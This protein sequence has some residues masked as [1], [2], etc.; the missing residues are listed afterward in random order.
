LNKSTIERANYYL[1]RVIV[2]DM[3]TLSFAVSKDFLS[4]VQTLSP[5]YTPPCE[6]TMKS[7]LFD[8][9]KNKLKPGL[10]NQLDLVPFYAFTTDGWKSRTKVAMQ[11]LEIHYVDPKTKLHHHRIL[12]VKEIDAEQ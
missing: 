1:A 7:I 9:Q 6:D 2:N 12:K 10:K 4:F 3:R 8:Y 5:L 11:S